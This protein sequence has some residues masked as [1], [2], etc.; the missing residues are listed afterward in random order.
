MSLTIPQIVEIQEAAKFNYAK[1]VKESGE[2]DELAK[3]VEERLEK[4]RA[5]RNASKS[6]KT[7]SATKKGNK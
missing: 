3:R 2:K 1:R 7:T 6:S 5:D 4:E